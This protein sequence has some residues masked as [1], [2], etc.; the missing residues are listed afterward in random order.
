MARHA[1][2]IAAAGGHHLLMV[3][4]PGAGKTMLASRLPGLLPVLDRDQALEAT[5]VISAAGVP[6]PPGGLVTR[7][8][9]RAPHHTATSAA[10]IGGGSGTAR[11]GE[12][13]LAHAGALFLD[14]IAEFAPKVL[15]GL[16]QP[17]EDRRIVVSR[18][19]IN[20]VLPADFLLVAAMNPCPCGG[21]APGECMCNATELHRYVRR[22]SGP[23]LDRFDLRVNVH[24]PSVDDLLAHE[25]AE[26]TAVVA[27]RVQAAR[28][29]AL[30]RQG[31]LNRSLSGSQLDEFAPINGPGR[32]VLRHELE[33]GRLSARGYHRIRRVARSI[34][35]LRSTAS[36]VVDDE[37]VHLALGL[38]A[39]FT[40]VL[41]MGRVA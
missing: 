29:R 8:P 16:R 10:L 39:A 7:P 12:V 5:M 30:S 27:E 33:N 37:A 2:E 6:L 36:E 14:E 22:L 26:S 41:P 32:A 3:G 13:S 11:P 4:P 15:D 40:K 25:P 18:S 21:G 19:G 35:D 17:L 24:R 23:L 38:R 34:A 28:V 9:F 31:C 1:L 20:A